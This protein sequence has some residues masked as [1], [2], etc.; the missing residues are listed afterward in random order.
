MVRDVPK[1]VK[2]Q[3]EH[4]NT[5]VQQIIWE[6]RPVKKLNDISHL[7]PRKNST[8]SSSLSTDAHKI[9]NTNHLNIIKV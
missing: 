9:L 3:M 7:R 2:D 6:S 4:E 1:I 5:V 8:L